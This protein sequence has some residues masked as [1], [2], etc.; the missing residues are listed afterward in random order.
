[1]KR[2]SPHQLLALI[3]L[4][5][6]CSDL[7]AQQV[8]P[9]QPI[10]P[11]HT[12]LAPVKS[13][14]ASVL[15]RVDI[16]TKAIQGNL[17]VYGKILPEPVLEKDSLL[18]LQMIK[19]II[20][21]NMALDSW[22]STL[23]N[24]Y[25]N[26]YFTQEPDLSMVAFRSVAD[27]NFTTSPD[28]S[29]KSATGFAD[30][31]A[32]FLVNRTKTELNAA[33]LESLSEQCQKNIYLQK[34]FPSTG[35]LLGLMQERVY[36]FNPFLVEIRDAAH[37]DLRLLPENL[38]TF[39]DS[40]TELPI[41]KRE[42]IWLADALFIRDMMLESDFETEMVFERLSKR[43]RLDDAS[44]TQKSIAAGLGMLVLGAECFYDYDLFR[45]PQYRDTLY[46]D[47][48][49]GVLYEDYRNMS[50]GE[51]NLGMV[52][53]TV[54]DDTLFQLFGRYRDVFID[55]DNQIFKKSES[56]TKNAAKSRTDEYRFLEKK[57]ETRPQFLPVIESL[58]HT[59]QFAETFMRVL[60]PT[61]TATHRKLRIGAQASDYFTR[62]TWK[63]YEKK[64]GEVL[65]YTGSL[66][67][68]IAGDNEVTCKFMRY[69]S[70]LSSLPACNN[71]DEVAALIE[72]FALPPGSS[73]I[74]K[75]SPFTVGIGSYVGGFG[76]WE[77]LKNV[78]TQDRTA[79]TLSLSAPVGLALSKAYKG[80]AF[81]D[82]ATLIDVG[83]F[84]AFRFDDS[85][86]TAELPAMTL[87]NIFAPGAAF[88]V[89]VPR[90]P[91]AFG[92][93][94]QVGPN[95]RGITENG[96]YQF[97]ETGAWRFGA[98]VTV[99]IPLLNFYTAGGGDR[100]F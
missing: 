72:T 31:L 68:L 56:E 3:C 76:G 46:R 48:F 42:R 60:T 78:N 8:T 82:F 92:L 4:F 58:N 13:Y 41:P 95:I 19:D 54:A 55:L 86:Y 98:T 65:L 40:D 39:L 24:P 81:T 17:N 50:L 80:W 94:A 83:A 85:N 99:D 5:C 77:F 87:A 64:W 37:A 71:S 75:Q 74:K 49:L 34:L 67:A 84:T 88:V 47:I 79:T 38:A 59:M 25:L 35:Q 28:F 27:L 14:D 6:F 10:L 36:N 43:I 44:P 29:D 73:R 16:I 90:Y 2:I 21:F 93:N 97:N 9:P 20:Q 30:G 51:K 61:D 1:M 91:F 52:M 23:R 89:G 100:C 63:T 18:Q 96:V 7:W 22:S 57:P 69:G 11:R 62:L 70:F 12:M 66:V 33:F 32:K 26:R 45:W 15:K 53:P